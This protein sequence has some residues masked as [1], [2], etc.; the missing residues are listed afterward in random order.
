MML[1]RPGMWT[2]HPQSYD[3]M[4]RS[5][6]DDL[7]F[8][9][10]RDRDLAEI[11]AVLGGYGKVGVAGPFIALFGKD[12][13]CVDEVASVFA[14]QFH[15]L[16]YLQLERQHDPEAWRRLTAGLRDRFDSQDVRRSTVEATFGPPS[17]VVGH[18]VLCYAPADGSGW[19]F[20][21]C[22]TEYH[23]EY[24]P[25]TGSYAQRRDSDP[26]VRAIRHPAADFE[27]GLILTRYGKV[28]RWGPGWWME[29][30]DGLPPGHQAIASQLRDIEA[31]DPSQALRPPR[32][33]PGRSNSGAV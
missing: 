21:D 24:R 19:V 2:S 18:R 5:L 32:G 29:H 13:G 22:F 8:L 17:L 10:E 14:E 26:L 12:C 25:E 4:A 20:F 28:L 3:A 11:Q 31:R 9:D 23:Q 15:R 30:P 27:S 6:L 33:D 7:C 16:G 1:T